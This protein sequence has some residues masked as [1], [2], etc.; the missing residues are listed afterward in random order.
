[1]DKVRLGLVGCGGMGQGHIGAMKELAEAQLTVVCDVDVEAAKKVGTENGVPYFSDYQ[2]MMKSGLCDAVLVVTPHYFHHEIGIAAFKAGLHVLSEKPI[3]VTVSAADAFISAA[4]KS[5]KVFSVMFQQR[6]TPEMRLAHE[7]VKSGR[8]GEIKRTLMVYADY[9]SQ[10]Y[11]SSAGWRGTWLGEGGGVLLNQAPHSIDL[12]MLLG[13]LPCR[14]TAKTRTRLHKIEVEDEA[15]ALLE[16]PNGAWGYYYACTCEAPGVPGMEITG[17]RG[18]LVWRNGELK[19]FSFKPSTSE[20]N[21]TCKMMWGGPEVIEEKMELP[22]AE[23]GHKEIIR[24]FCTAILHGE[25]LIAPGVEGI[26]AVEFINALILSGKKGKPVEIPVNRQEY[27]R[28]L[29]KLKKG[30]KAKKV[31]KVERVTD[32]KFAKK[33]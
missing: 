33:S 8:L 21:A 2:K 26:W 11:Y 23:T 30:S 27:D 12:F 18:R 32:P 29:A 3:T 13:G 5:K 7:I 10:A 31:A 6:T 25:E 20:H 1:M 28:L 4:K 22:E 19:F 16:Y 14:V 15:C 9:R 24:N 17:N